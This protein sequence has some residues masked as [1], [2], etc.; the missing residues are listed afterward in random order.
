MDD[1]GQRKS[2]CERRGGPSQEAGVSATLLLHTLHMAGGA[3]TPGAAQLTICSTVG[4]D[5]CLRVVRTVGC[6]RRDGRGAPK[7]AVGN[8]RVASHALRTCREPHPDHP[9]SVSCSC[10]SRRQDRSG[11]WPPSASP[12][13]GPSPQSHQLSPEPFLSPLARA[14]HTLGRLA[15]APPALG[16]TPTQPSRSRRRRQ[17]HLSGPPA[18]RCNHGAQGP[19]RLH[20]VHC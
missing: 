3:S 17:P 8:R 15:H 16:P 20:A 6:C 10:G 14:A 19:Q 4:G 18:Q 2:G 7:Q 11:R 5:S 1:H 13:R 9:R 12:V